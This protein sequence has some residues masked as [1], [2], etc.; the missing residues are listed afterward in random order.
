MI[1]RLVV[2]VEKPWKKN[3]GFS[4]SVA[5]SGSAAALSF[6]SSIKVRA[7]AGFQGHLLVPTSEKRSAP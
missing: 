6:K 7:G 2:I 5:C 3:L 4:I 1:S